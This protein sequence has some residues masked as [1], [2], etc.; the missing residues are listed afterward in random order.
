MLWILGRHMLTRTFLLIV[1]HVSLLPAVACISDSAVFLR[2]YQYV[3]SPCV[4]CVCVHLHDTSYPMMDCI[5]TDYC[6]A[7]MAWVC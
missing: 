6:V 4:V 5:S 3:L 1:C 7:D 2:L